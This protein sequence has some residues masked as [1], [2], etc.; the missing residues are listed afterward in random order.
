MTLSQ[1]APLV[2]LTGCLAYGEP[3]SLEGLVWSK[4]Y[5]AAWVQPVMSGKVMTTIYHPAR[6]EVTVR[7]GGEEGVVDNEGLYERVRVGQKVGVLFHYPIN[8]DSSIAGQP[9]I[10]EVYP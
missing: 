3:Q 7:Y 4:D 9:H 10:I 6:Y 2:L 5:R 8:A 1:I